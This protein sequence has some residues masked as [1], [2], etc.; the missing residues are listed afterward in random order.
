MKLILSRKGFDTKFGGGPS[1]L[2]D[3]QRIVS[4]PIEYGGRETRRR[5]SDIN[6]DG[7]NLGDLVEQLYSKRKRDDFCHLDPD[8]RK[9]ALAHRATIDQWR[10]LFG[11][12]NA[13]ASHLL[14]QRVGPGDLFLF[15]GLFR[16]TNGWNFFVPNAPEF[17]FIYGWFQVDEVVYDPISWANR[18]E[19]TWAQDHPH[20]YGDWSGK[21]NILFTARKHLIIDGVTHPIPGAGL[22]DT[23]NERL[24]LSDP[25]S[26]LK[27][28]WRL[29]IALYPESGTGKS[30]TYLKNAT[31]EVEPSQEYVRMN[32]GRTTLWQEAVVSGNQHAVD[33]ATELISDLTCDIACDKE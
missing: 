25:N 10:P 32:P 9:D 33:W 26:D 29:P 28:H 24:R 8:L 2:I 17:H 15:F 30:I 18:E 5:F 6:L 21:K 14:S 7:M 27:S 19:N 11:Q 1:P 4:L 20:T 31:W 12:G 13:A 23:Y 16:A 22:F 3:G